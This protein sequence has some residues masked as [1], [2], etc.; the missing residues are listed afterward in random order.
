[1]CGT[2]WT[3]ILVWEKTRMRKIC[4]TCSFS[5]T[6][7]CSTP[8]VP[9]PNHR[10]IYSCSCKNRLCC[11]MYGSKQT[12]CFSIPMMSYPRRRCW[13]FLPQRRR[14]RFFSPCVK[15]SSTALCSISSALSRDSASAVWVLLPAAIRSVYSA[16]WRHRRRYALL[17]RLICVPF[18]P[19][20]NASAAH[21]IPTRILLCFCVAPSRNTADSG[22]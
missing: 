21:Y 3:P 15:G 6:P 7:R 8:P 9:M 19:V 22:P 13:I 14:N 5:R 16:P 11:E 17:P 2:I 18:L 10:C 12:R 4:P 1:M 20:L